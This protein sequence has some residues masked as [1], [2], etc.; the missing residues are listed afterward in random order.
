MKFETRAI[1]VAMDI[2]NPSASVVPPISPSTIFEIDA[3]GRKEGDLH[4][5]RLGK[6]RKSVV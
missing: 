2:H 3:E 4:Y 5:T 6:D 1:H